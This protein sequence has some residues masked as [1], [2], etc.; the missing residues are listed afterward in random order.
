MTNIYNHNRNVFDFFVTRKNFWDFQLSV[1]QHYALPE[2]NDSN[3]VWWD[4]LYSKNDYTW[5]DAI[6]NG[7]TL[8]NFG[9]T[10]VDNGYIT[11]D[12]T[13]ISN[14]EF[15]KIFLNTPYNAQKDDLRLTLCKVNGNNQIYDYSNDIVEVD[16][17]LAAKLNG[18]FYQGIMHINEDYQI[19]PLT[20]DNSGWNFELVLK[21]EDF[22]NSDT[23]INDTHSDNKGM[24]FY[25]GTRAENKWIANYTATTDVEQSCN[26]YFGDD[27]VSDDYKKNSSYTNTYVKD[28]VND[29]SDRTNFIKDNYVKGDYAKFSDDLANA[30]VQDEYIKKETEIQ[31]SDVVTSDGYDVSQ[32]NIVEIKTD[33]KFITFN[34]TKE[35][36]DINNFDED[37]EVILTDIKESRN[38]PNY[39]TLFSRTKDGYD[40][41]SI[42]E[43]RNTE[44]KKYNFLQDLYRNALGF[45]IKDDGSI[46]YK[47]LVKDCDSEE[48]NYKIE[49]EFSKVNI[50][51]DDTWQVVNIMIQGKDTKKVTKN[52]KCYGTNKFSD[53]MT[54]KIYVNGK[55]VLKSKELPMINLKKLNDLDSRQEGVPFNI[56]IGGGTQGLCDAIYENFREVPE[57]LLPIEKEFCGSF[58]GY[59]KS[60]KFYSCPLK[61]NERE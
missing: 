43:L 8:E 6:N 35:G 4:K 34:R 36:F 5:S 1:N 29:N 44:N 3:C 10:G 49:S 59:L 16:G 25:I 9:L 32:P 30:Y 51:K 14:E 60:F 27:Y 50:I 47:Y 54:I 42:D 22:T 11:F 55:L 12:K 52:G 21:K 33:N 48:E 57:N 61:I 45:Q 24:F 7:V 40:I 53:K 13:K 41:N 15:L 56:S 37:A 46:G 2:I 23:T 26:H 18:G 38:I 28:I 19:L 58:I 31:K 39:F 17:K 20:L